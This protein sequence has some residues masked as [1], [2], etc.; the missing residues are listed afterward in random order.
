MDPRPRNIL[1]AIV[2]ALALE[3]VPPA[4][5]AWVNTAKRIVSAGDVL[6]GPAGSRTRTVASLQQLPHRIR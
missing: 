3:A 6:W 5:D 2:L 1:I 4:H